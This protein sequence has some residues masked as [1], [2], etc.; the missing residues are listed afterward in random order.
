LAVLSCLVATPALADTIRIVD[1][2]FSD[3]SSSV[4]DFRIEGQSFVLLGTATGGNLQ[5]CG[6]C[7]PGTPF[8]LSGLYD[9]EGPVEFNGETTSAVG[10]FSFD[11]A[12][13]FI[14]QLAVGQQA[15]LTR[16]F[17]FLGTVVLDGS[18]IQHQVIGMGLATARFVN[19]AGEGIFPTSIRYDFAS[20]VPEPTSM[21]LLGSGLA[22][23]AAT[24]ARRRRARDVTH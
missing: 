23:A 15:E 8:T 6:P 2:T 4:A 3:S 18:S 21:L 12:A 19:N 22:A 10:R 11:A 16:A 17:Q 7:L 20:A 24:R 14:P 9:L 13:I 5:Q 1:G